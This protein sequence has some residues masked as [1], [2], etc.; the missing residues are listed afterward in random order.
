MITPTTTSQLPQ[1]EACSLCTFNN[2]D[3]L[4]MPWTCGLGGLFSFGKKKEARP[5]VWGS[6]QAYVQYRKIK[7]SG[8]A[9]RRVG[10]VSRKSWPGGPPADAR[11]VRVGCGAWA[12][13]R[14][15][16]TFLFIGTDSS[17][18][19]RPSLKLAALRSANESE[20]DFCRSREPSTG[21]TPS[22][23]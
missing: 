6:Q 10:L 19:P 4:R 22:G 13:D 23:R 9:Y 11:S 5:Q 3:M 2:F 8:W 20:G 21:H 15:S 18:L 14:A 7:G 12:A 1:V 17:K 16:K